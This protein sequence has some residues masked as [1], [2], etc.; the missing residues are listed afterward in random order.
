MAFGSVRYF[1]LTSLFLQRISLIADSQSRPPLSQRLASGLT[2]VRPSHLR[3]N[4]NIRNVVGPSRLG[5][6]WH[7]TARVIALKFQVPARRTLPPRPIHH[8]KHE[9]ANQ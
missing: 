1:K 9:S 3:R 8:L 7:V 6:H 2:V 5:D 4:R